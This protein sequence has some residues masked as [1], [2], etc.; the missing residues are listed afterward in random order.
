[1][2]RKF[3]VIGDTVQVNT[4]VTQVDINDI[5]QGKSTITPIDT[6][7]EESL[8]PNDV[9]SEEDKKRDAEYD[10]QFSAEVK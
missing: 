9:C 4:P 10:S 8:I 6:P 3:E 1:M 5:R 7:K 2:E